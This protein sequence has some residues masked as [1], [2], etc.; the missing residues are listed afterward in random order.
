MR[1]PVS[2]FLP[3]SVCLALA[4]CGWGGERPKADAAPPASVNG[5]SADYPMVLG[6]PFTIDG[7]TYTPADRL[8]YDAVGRASVGEAGGTS[9]SVAHKTLPLPSYAEVTSLDTGKTILARVERRGP[10]VNDLLAELSPG[11]AAQLGVEA[12]SVTALRIRRVNP[13]EAERALLRGGQQAPQRMDT[14]RSLLAVLARKLDSAP[15]PVAISDAPAPPIAAPPASPS[16]EATSLPVPLSV[17]APG[18]APA[19]VEPAVTTPPEP[20]ASPTVTRQG[21]HVVQVAVFSTEER[22]KAAS[23][24]LGATYR[25]NG[26]FWSMRLGPFATRAEADRALA[27][28]RSAGYSDARIQRA[29]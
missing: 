3:V 4:A 21:G 8:N 27:R 26:R 16:P 25:Q 18:D 28:A 10:M 6:E 19:N 22:A 13:P 2:Y 5:P 15:A 7:V 20:A 1:L 11:A 12:G 24:K 29:D 17:P 23:G 9:V 14:P